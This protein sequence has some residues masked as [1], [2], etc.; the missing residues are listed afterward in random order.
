MSVLSICCLINTEQHVKFS[1]PVLEQ[2]RGIHV[3]TF[4]R[5]HEIMLSVLESICNHNSIAFPLIN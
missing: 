3:R 1:T 2:N 5:L 4:T